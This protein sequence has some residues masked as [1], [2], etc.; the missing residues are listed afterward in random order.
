MPDLSTR[1]VER[2]VA[3]QNQSAQNF[4][5]AAA[6]LEEWAINDDPDVQK[7]LIELGE[8]LDDFVSSDIRN[9]TALG[10][11]DILNRIRV[12]L[13]YI[14]PHRR[15]MLLEWAIRIDRENGTSLVQ[16]LLSMP[17]AT[18]HVVSVFA[19]IMSIEPEAAAMHNRAFLRFMNAAELLP[20]VFGKE[21]VDLVMKAIGRSLL[22]EEAQ[23]A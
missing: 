7:S 15:L 19:G 3:G 22:K 18:N 21:R 23:H 5:N 11:D 10:R 1:A 8:A 17:G 12:L 9:V 14:G 2:W 6:H 13:A 16:V 4:L 20:V